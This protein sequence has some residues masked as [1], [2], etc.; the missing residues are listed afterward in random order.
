MSL[1]QVDFRI[2]SN[3]TEAQ[4]KA[5][6]LVVTGVDP[7]LKSFR[8]DEIT[9]GGERELSKEYLFSVRYTR[10]NV[11]HAMEDH[12]ILPDLGE[13]EKLSR[14]Q[15]GRR[16]SILQLDKGN[17]TLKSAKPQR[18][19]NGV[20]FILTKRFSKNYFYSAETIRGAACLETTPASPA[21]TKAAE[22]LRVSIVSSIIRSMDI[23][24]PAIPTTDCWRRTARIPL[25]HTVDIHLIGLEARTTARTLAFSS[26][27]LE[28]K[29][30]ADHV[31]HGC[32]DRDPA[33]Q[34]WRSRPYASLLADRP[35]T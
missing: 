7:N 33:L 15:P 2:P 30:P 17:G 1:Q 3:L 9:F 32:K 8:Q 20:E 11:A 19:Y 28:G 14:R 24:L 10:K 12:A 18:T 16:P 31:H 4:F 23:P 21:R 13:A 27:I 6:G 25:R 22:H 26:R 34:A 35:V 29:R 5:L